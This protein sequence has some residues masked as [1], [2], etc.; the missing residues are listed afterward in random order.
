MQPYSAEA[1][2][3]QLTALLPPG[4]AWTCEADSVLAAL[5][6]AMAQEPARVDSAAHELLA[7]LDP[8]Q[9]FQ[10]LTRWESEC[11]LPD[12]C[13]QLGETVSQRREAVVAK[14]ASLGGQTPEYFADL[15]TI[16]TGQ[17]CTI[18]EYRPFRAG[19]SHAGDPLSNG[20]WVFTFAVVVPATPVHTFR[21]GQSGAGEPLRKWG[22]ER[23]ECTIKRLAPAHT[24]VKFYY[25]T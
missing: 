15:A 20:D 12:T 22:N 2:A 3:S 1:Y 9:T 17:I 14:L 5:L 4:A 10:L 25:G 23:L 24:I 16:L 8:F 13:S 18:K 6:L 19:R 7:E 21:A 11:G